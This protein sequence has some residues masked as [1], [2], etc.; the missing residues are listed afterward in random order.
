MT[1]PNIAALTSI[2]GKTSVADV[3]IAGVNVISNGT[4]SGQV[5]KVNSLIISNIDGTNNAEVTVNLVRGANSYAFASAIVV[6]AKSTLVAISKDMGVYIE[7]G[8]A[9]NCSAG[10]DGD[11]QVLCSYEVIESV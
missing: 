4:S 10:A 7:E 5:F 6:P 9:I 8:D 2:I 3:T 11:L 1:A